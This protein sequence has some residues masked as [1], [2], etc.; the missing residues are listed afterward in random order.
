ME[1]MMSM[2]KLS[3]Y[4]RNEYSQFGEDG[5]IEQIFKILGISSKVCVEFGAWDGFYLSNT[6]NLWTNGWKAILIEADKTK[7][8]ELVK[9]VKEYNCRCINAFVG[10]EGSNTLENILKRQGI[11]DD[12]D[13]LSID[14]DGDDYYILESLEGLQPRL[15]VCEFNP[16]IPSH[17]ELIPEKG[18]YFGCSALS[19]VKLAETK[20]YR[21]VAVSDGNCFFVRVEDFHKFAAYETNLE[22]IMTKKHLTYLITGFDGDYILSKKPAFGAYY[23]SSQK[24]RGQYYVFKRSLFRTLYSW[25]KKFLGILGLRKYVFDIYGKMKKTEMTNK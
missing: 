21:L 9:N 7:Y 4:A 10:Y 20:G 17:M 2:K 6:A 18:N 8:K 19:L 3:D 11:S 5:I 13:L 16:T 15:I 23:P 12:I 22:S 1:K 14:V 24:F 25:M